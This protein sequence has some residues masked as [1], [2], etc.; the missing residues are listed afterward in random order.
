MKYVETLRKKEIVLLQN[1]ENKTSKYYK[2]KPKG[3]G[4]YNR[5]RINQEQ[6]YKIMGYY[7]FG[8]TLQ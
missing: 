3:K 8:G 2:A 6:Y 7:L 4:H 1:P 5:V